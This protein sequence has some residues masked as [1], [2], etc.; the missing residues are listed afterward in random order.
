MSGNPC[1]SGVRAAPEPVSRDLPAASGRHGAKKFRRLGKFFLCSAAQCSGDQPC[2]R[3]WLPRHPCR[4]G[5]GALGG[6]MTI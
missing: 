1:F 5:P 2:A 3:G 4:P 6:K